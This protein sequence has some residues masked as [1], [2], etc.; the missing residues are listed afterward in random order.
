MDEYNPYEDLLEKLMNARSLSDIGMEDKNILIC[1]RKAIK[2][3]L[4]YKEESL[5]LNFQ[6]QKLNETQRKLKDEYDPLKSGEKS[7][8]SFNSSEAYF[9][10]FSSDSSLPLEKFRNKHI[11]SLEDQVISLK[12]ENQN[13][14]ELIE[15]QN[16]HY[17]KKIESKNKVISAL[18]SELNKF[19][20]NQNKRDKCVHFE[21]TNQKFEEQRKIR[22]Y[23][24]YAI[25]EISKQMSNSIS[26]L[27]YSLTNNKNT[28]IRPL[29][30]SVLFSI[31]WKNIKK[32]NLQFDKFSL[33]AFASSKLIGFDSRID[34][35]Y[36]A[37]KSLT[38]ELVKVKKQLQQ[39]IKSSKKILH[40]FNETERKLNIN[41][42]KYQDFQRQIS[43]Y[44][45]KISELNEEMSSMITSE[46]FDEIIKH[47]TSI[48]LENDKL[49]ANI[50][51]LEQKL[52]EKDNEIFECKKMCQKA[53]VQHKID[54]DQQKE[55]QNKINSQRIDIGLLNV[56]LKNRTKDLLSYERMGSNM[57]KKL[58]EKQIPPQPDDEIQYDFSKENI[59]P[60][61]LAPTNI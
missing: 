19:S 3:L 57:N 58:F 20:S 54:I 27:Y 50:E 43:F 48:N 51:I 10:T 17:K 34:N 16:L 38:D 15:K 60:K 32:K 31:R 39:N 61:F 5:T 18:Q 55:D 14:K 46:K 45:S 47:Y 1:F 33:M 13:L 40:N 24:C 29:I 6:I 56:R 30:L 12:E 49:K 53:E 7:D 9:V 36:N 23:F 37:F 22:K 26:N 59:N 44:K 21:S 35:I 42:N 11:K 28:I 52:E 2:E 8:H 25:S 41:Q 4:Q